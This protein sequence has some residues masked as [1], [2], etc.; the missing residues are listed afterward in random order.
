MVARYDL[1]MLHTPFLIGRLEIPNRFLRS[2]TAERLADEEGRPL[3]GMAPMYAELVRGGVGL[4]ISGH[5]YVH[6][7]GKAHPEM[8]AI[9]DDARIPELAELT[10]VV[11]AE[12]GR[13]AAQVNHGGMQ[14]TRDATAEAI[15]PSDIE[16]PFLPRP[17]RGMS[18]AEVETLVD[19]Y[20]QAARR[21]QEAGFDAVQIHAA[22]GYLV[23]QFLSPYVNR[24]SD[25]W[26]GDAANRRRF[27]REVCRSARAQVGADFPLF[28]KLGVLDGLEQ[29]LSVEEGRAIVAEL[30]QM[31]FDAVEVSGGVGGRDL[32]ARAG[33]KKLE[34]EA[35]FREAVRTVRPAT[36]L[37]LA[38]VGGLRTPALMR[39]ILEAGEADFVSLCRPLICE[40]DFPRQ[41]LAGRSERSN[42]LSGNTCWP[43]EDGV[44]VS[45]KCPRKEGRTP[46]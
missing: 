8:T 30:A 28:L 5:M 29:G 10:R 15:A 27:L 33:V 45:C 24:R 32:N 11:H 42:C 46:Q 40:P 4:I 14:C 22:H 3:P 34:H 6:R 2:A 37:P 43:E 20:A 36:P 19:A 17:A 16:A 21:A 41:V 38:I 1:A 31:G 25:E 39:E 9:D 13:I 7:S 23:S 12:G 26:G 44:G 35:Y 18:S